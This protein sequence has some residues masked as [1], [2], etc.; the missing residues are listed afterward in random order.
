[1]HPDPEKKRNRGYL[2]Y[3]SSALPPR[4]RLVGH[5][6]T[7]TT[8]PHCVLPLLAAAAA[9]HAAA[10]AADRERVLIG[11][12]NRTASSCAM[13]STSTRGTCG[14]GASPP[15][16]SSPTRALLM[17][18][19]F[20]VERTTTHPLIPRG[21]AAPS[22]RLTVACDSPVA[23]CLADTT[24]LPPTLS[25][26]PSRLFTS[27]T[28]AGAASSSTSLRCS[29]MLTPHSP[30]GHC[31]VNNPRA[32][33]EWQVRRRPTAVW[34]PRR[35]V[36]E[37]PP[38]WDRAG[39]GHRFHHWSR[40]E[41]QWLQRP[42]VPRPLYLGMSMSASDNPFPSCH[43]PPPLSSTFSSAP[44]FASAPPCPLDLCSDLYSGGL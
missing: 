42:V 33:Q 4:D 27:P 26:L 31:P 25:S 38:L 32:D 7:T 13:N 36:R 20:V 3:D 44:P 21:W 9:A 28:N 14:F 8:T 39:A 22:T 10:H 41:Q 23:L 37:D 34:V 24:C 5:S 1:M 19:N 11:A 17:L 6:T 12:N 35:Q 29:G 16:G 43:P 18:L 2:G 30:P 40:H 15:P